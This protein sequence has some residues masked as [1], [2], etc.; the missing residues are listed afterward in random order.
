M[1]LYVLGTGH[2]GVVDG[3]NTCFILENNGEKLLVDAGGGKQVLK[4]IRDVGID[5]NKVNNAFITHTHTDHLLGMIWVIRVAIQGYMKGLRNEPLTIWG[6]KVCLDAIK[7][8]CLI[9]LGE[10]RFNDSLNKKVFLKEV[11]DG[12]RENIIGTTFEFFD[13]KND[14]A[15]QM[16]FYIEKEQFVFAGDVYLNEC[17][18]EKFKNQKVVC[19]EAFCLDKYKGKNRFALTSHKTVEE[20]CNIAIVLNPEKLI[21]WHRDD[22]V[23]ARDEYLNVA[24]KIFKNEV[25]VPNDLEI[26]EL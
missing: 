20:A 8:I 5:V 14:D 22:Y 2:A 1:K 18:Y 26:I 10:R 7:S 6:S 15:S 19:L 16:A 24:N 23:G 11:N 9:T 4:Q 12:Q 21:L 13:T 17:Y 3:Y 25:I